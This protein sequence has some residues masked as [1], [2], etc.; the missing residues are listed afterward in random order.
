V[1]T[2]LSMPYAIVFS[3]FLYCSISL[4]GQS[5]SLRITCY[6]FKRGR[7]SSFLLVYFILGFGFGFCFGFF[8]CVLVLVL[9]VLL[10]LVSNLVS[11]SVSR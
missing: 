6:E 1:T 4:S 11:V 7:V 5:R 2:T 8:V 10:V 3:L 9:L